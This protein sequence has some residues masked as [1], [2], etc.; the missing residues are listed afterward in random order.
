MHK[1][2]VV[3]GY[4]IHIVQTKANF[5]LVRWIKLLKE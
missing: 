5:K 2:L 4:Y 1:N 3:L